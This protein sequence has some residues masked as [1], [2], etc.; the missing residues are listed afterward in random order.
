MERSFLTSVLTIT[1]D[2]WLMEDFDRRISRLDRLLRKRWSQRS[3]FTRGGGDC[4]WM[5]N[6]PFLFL[7]ARISGKPGT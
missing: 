3:S 6:I 7:I 1:G 4:V 2:K 5:A